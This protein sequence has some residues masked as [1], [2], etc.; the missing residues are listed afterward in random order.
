ML[1]PRFVSLGMS[2]G[3]RKHTLPLTCPGALCDDMYSSSLPK[4]EPE[5]QP[6][7][8]PETSKHHPTVHVHVLVYWTA[9]EPVSVL[10]LE[11]R[12]LA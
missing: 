6:D 11:E 7:P 8:V 4:Q 12:R 3:I 2:I 9:T 10:F 5:S 1:T